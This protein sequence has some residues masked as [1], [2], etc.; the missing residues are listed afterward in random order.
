M[1]MSFVDERLKICSTCPEYRPLAL[2]MSQ[3]QA[4]GCVIQM[5]ALVPWA[6]CPK[7]L[8]PSSDNI[9]QQEIDDIIINDVAMGRM[10]GAHDT[11]YGQ[12]L[13]RQFTERFGA[14]AD[15][16]ALW[17]DLVDRRSRAN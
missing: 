10:N 8:W 14:N 7:N 11:P 16:N 5:K 2:G 3:C 6:S 15:I 1:N 17:M 13:E 4:C 12:H 9:K